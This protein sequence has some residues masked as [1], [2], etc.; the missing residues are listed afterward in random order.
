[1][2]KQPWHSPTT[3]ARQEENKTKQM[4]MRTTWKWEE[5]RNYQWF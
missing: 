4:M 1:M 3:E 2:N 5:N